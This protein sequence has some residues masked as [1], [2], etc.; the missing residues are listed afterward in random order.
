MSTLVLPD[1]RNLT[2]GFA[3]AAYQL[4][5]RFAA[6]DMGIASFEVRTPEEL[7]RRVGEA[8]VLVVS[9]LWHNELLAI[10][11]TLRFV[12][13]ISAGVNQYDQAQF[14]AQ[15]VR[16]ASAQGVN[17]V[18]VAEHAIA[19]L[20]ALRRQLHTARDNQARQHWRPMISDIAAREGELSGK[21]LLIVGYGR[22][23]QRLARLAKA[24][25]MAVIGVRRSASGSPGP[26]DAVHRIE[27][28]P[29]LLGGADAVALTCPLTPETTGLIN[30]AALSRM[31]PSAILINV[32]RGAV[33]DEPA[34]VS[35]L[36]SRKI[37]A[38]GIDVTVEEP[39]PAGS[40]LWRLENA[41]ITPHTAG[42]TQAYE[43]NVLDV[44]MENLGRM[45]RG[46]QVLRNQVV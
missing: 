22:I 24:F 11:P 2:I 28:L 40:A 21:T 30:A 36:Q 6:R 25:D 15:G 12:Q 34:L 43:D 16:L 26:A 27:K 3:H 19:M 5:A 10:A 1:K 39:L 35:A 7:K 29:E 38:A 32:A 9:G 42:E 37:A 41:L 17:E 20:L 4:G 31:K 33:V 23:G 45:W 46:E 44:L 13:S 14:R 8:D 18:A